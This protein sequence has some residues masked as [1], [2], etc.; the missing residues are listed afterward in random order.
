MKILDS[1]IAVLEPEL[2]Q[3]LSRWVERDDDLAAYDPRIRGVFVPMIPPGGVAVDGG[4]HIGDHTVAY[5]RQAG[6]A[7]RVLAFEPVP[8]FLRCLMHNTR[9]L[10]QVTVLPLG[11]GGG[12]ERRELNVST[13]N[14]GGS[15][16]GDLN[17]DGFQI[18]PLDLFRFPRLDF[19]KLDLEGFELRALRGSLRTLRKHR[20]L[21]AVETGPQLQHYGD[22]HDEMVQFMQSLGYTCEKLP[23]ERPGDPVHD[24]LFRPA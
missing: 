24:V 3:L 2:D 10:P 4:A 19:V 5:A 8:A 11:L 15:R 7:G 12:V 23:E 1:G 14:A 18:V 6:P 16:L 22:S 13:R 20:P 9:D 21:V 17:I